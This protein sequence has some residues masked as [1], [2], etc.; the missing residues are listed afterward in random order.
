MSLSP[1]NLQREDTVFRNSMSE[2][3]RRIP[4]L[5]E[6]TEPLSVDKSRDTNCSRNE[7]S[8]RESL[9]RPRRKQLCRDPSGAV[10]MRAINHCGQTNSR[11]WQISFYYRIPVFRNLERYFPAVPTPFIY[12]VC[13]YN[14]I[15]PRGLAIVPAHRQRPSTVR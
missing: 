3:H 13:R 12:Q 4:K 7:L 5:I 15:G 10:E 6:E 14:F 8:P 1:E 9:M 2:L 11:H